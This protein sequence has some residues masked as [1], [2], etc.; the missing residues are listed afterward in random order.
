MEVNQL[1]PLLDKPRKGVIAF[2]L[3]TY[4]HTDARCL[5]V[6]K[7]RESDCVKGANSVARL[8]RDSVHITE[9]STVAD[10][11]RQ[12]IR[13]RFQRMRI[14]RTHNEIDVTSG[15][16]TSP[17]KT[18]TSVQP[19]YGASHQNTPTLS[20]R[21]NGQ[22]KVA[23][24][25]VSRPFLVRIQGQPARQAKQLLV[26]PLPRLHDPQSS[27]RLEQPIWNAVLVHDTPRLP[28]LCTPSR[29]TTLPSRLASEQKT[30]RKTRN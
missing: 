23:S 12:R 29:C 15:Q 26:Q 17:H 24:N 21:L 3:H 2:C 11:C 7:K 22:A 14:T 10:V 19:T 5:L 27:L 25:S 9:E 4:M 30:E 13:E 8:A 1:L 16:H 18:E 20:Q 6:R 28:P